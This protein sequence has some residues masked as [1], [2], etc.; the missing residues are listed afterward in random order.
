[1]QYSLRRRIA[2]AGAAAA[3]LLLVAQALGV[4][5]LAEAQEERLISAVIGDDLREILQ[6][7]Q[8]HPASIPPLDPLLGARVSQETGEYMALPPELASLKEGTHEVIV[9]GREIHVAVVNFRDER[10]YRVFDYSAYERH[11]KDAISALMVV[12]GVFSLLA[13]WLAFWLS[14]FLMRQLV[15]R[16]KE[17]TGNVS[18][19]LR[20]PLTA[21]RTS[22]ELLEQD[23]A[24]VGKS[25]Q[26]LGQIENAAARMQAL[27]ASLLALAREDG[28]TEVTS[29]CLVEVIESI[30]LRCS[31]VMER[32]AV[33]PIIEVPSNATI[34][35]NAAALDIVLSNLIDNA[36]RHSQEGTLT[37]AYASGRLTIADSGC[38][39]APEALPHIFE[40]SYRAM[41][42]QQP[43]F[44][45]GLS[46]VKRIC[47]RYGW[48]IEVQS[49]LGCG[50]CVAL[51]FHKNFTRT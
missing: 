39:I 45:L 2:L 25:R 51:L 5:A 8:A 41:H 23:L 31:E 30:L 18:H 14:G 22:C 43:G 49:E 3:I 29:L 28:A 37:F 48:A 15:R 21:I 20:T 16:E 27:T 46:I 36:L 50:T 12:T 19:E 7:Y 9:D 11:F 1:M 38:G 4:R 40:R 44:G 34:C 33:R 17:F 13:I 35:A 42:S 47:D 10:I 32:R 6:S 26:R 24:I